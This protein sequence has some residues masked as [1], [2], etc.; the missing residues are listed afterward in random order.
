MPDDVILQKAAII[1]RCLARIEEVYDNNEKNLFEDMTKQDSIILNRQ[2]A[3]EASI[4]LAMHLIRKRGLGLPQESREAFGLLEDAGL[5][6][7]D[8][9]HRM[10]RM[11][12]F[13]AD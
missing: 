7:K 5:L 6:E 2:R 4:E 13:R 10:K 11:V 8:L 3:C 12:G 9:A 1:E